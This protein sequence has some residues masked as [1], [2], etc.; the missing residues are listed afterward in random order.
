METEQANK[1]SESEP[2][3]TMAGSCAP[4]PGSAYALVRLTDL[5][6]TKCPD[7]DT[8]YDAIRAYKS[9]EIA[10]IPLR[11]HVGAQTWIALEVCE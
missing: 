7:K 4:L 6:I 10:Y 2:S 9:R 8:L 11:W 3:F 1:A 5:R